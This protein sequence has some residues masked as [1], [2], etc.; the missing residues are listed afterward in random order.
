MSSAGPRI[1]VIRRR[2]IGD[3]VL[4]ESVFRMLRRH[5]PAAHI[6]AAVDPA[7]TTLLKLH[8]DVD[9]SLAL[10]VKPAHWPGLLLRLRREK[11]THVLDFDNRPRTALVTLFSGASLR[12][13]LRHGQKPRLG[14]CYTHRH[15][16]EPDY[17]DNRHI[18]DYYHRLLR[19]VGIVIK[20]EPGYLVPL[21]HEVARL[22]QLPEIA[23]LPPDT[24]RLLVHPG[25][26][27]PYRIWP[28]KNFAA[29]CD[30]IQRENLARVIFS[31]GP[32][33]HA[34]VEE[35]VSHMQTPAT[36]IEKSLTL[37]EL[38]ALFSV[39]DRVLCHDSGPM[40][41]AAAVG[42]P[43]V[44]LYGSQNIANW[45]PLGP[46]HITLQ[47]PL[48]CEHCVS[49][50]ICQKNDPYFNHCVRNITPDRVI[51]ALRACF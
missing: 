20:D 1:L 33:Q 43:V 46:D 39:M 5:W 3:I 11:F 24:P 32:G 18:T 28:A 38:A 23:A 17:L 34:L 8:P 51:N 12:A 26:R 2:Y 22:E 19:S 6:V 9:D 41:L 4:L 40:H 13:T 21:P 10:P 25:S 15:I 37:T 29:V 14:F 48:P 44:A 49:P 42:T 16:V 30:V 7:Y 31:A 50:G 27:S 35:I 47:P 36:V 45:R